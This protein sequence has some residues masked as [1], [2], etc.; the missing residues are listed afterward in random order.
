MAATTGWTT[1]LTLDLNLFCVQH[2]LTSPKGKMV[3]QQ[4][5]CYFFVKT[6]PTGEIQL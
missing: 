4:R 6:H 2:L 5:K 3:S 1:R